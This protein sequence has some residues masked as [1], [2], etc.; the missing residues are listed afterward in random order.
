MTR[1]PPPVTF[2]R[3]PVSIHTD[4][5]WISPGH[6]VCQPH[7]AAIPLEVR[8]RLLVPGLRNPDDT[9]RYLRAKTL[10]VEVAGLYARLAAAPKGSPE[11]ERM[12]AHLAALGALPHPLTDDQR[13]E[14]VRRRDEAADRRRQRMGTVRR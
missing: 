3:C 9:E 5:E 4:A 13:R 14:L 11:H 10:V 1:R 2:H 6:Q 12:T 7:W 8:W